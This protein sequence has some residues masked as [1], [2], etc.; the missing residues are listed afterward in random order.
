MSSLPETRQR[1]ILAYLR[2]SGTL[3]INELVDRL[4]VS[5]MTVHRDLNRLAEAGLVK[6]VHGGVTLPAA[7]EDIST[8]P[9]C[10]M[11]HQAINPRAAFV[12]HCPSGEQQHACCPHC[13]LMLTCKQTQP[14]LSLTTDFLY[15]NMVNARQATY[16]IGSGV[17]LCCMPSVLT[18]GSRAD[19]ERFQQGFGGALMDFAQ[20][21][22][23]LRG[24]HLIHPNP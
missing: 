17:T 24:S 13:G 9:R 5:P 22:Q 19:A 21:Q 15:G 10:A 11:C 7:E 1:Q 18:F 3:T 12:T 2:E 6:K 23:H 4:G 20:A 8:A 14:T 16:L